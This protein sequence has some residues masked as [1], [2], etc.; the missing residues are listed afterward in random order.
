MDR[1]RKVRL[2]SANGITGKRSAD[3]AL[4]SKDSIVWVSWE[5][6]ERLA[7]SQEELLKSNA[8]DKE[9]QSGERGARGESG[10]NLFKRRFDNE[11][12]VV[13]LRIE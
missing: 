2:G 10:R 9:I 4:D 11:I 8:V 12:E 5:A 1:H 7:H 3:R 13:K 6:W